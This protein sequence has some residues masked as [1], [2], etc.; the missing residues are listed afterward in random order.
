MG[1]KPNYQTSLQ[2]NEKDFE[3]KEDLSER[4]ISI[5]DTWRRGA[6]ELIREIAQE[7]KNG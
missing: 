3:V 5:I 1:I 4:G 6:Q 7:N 2:L